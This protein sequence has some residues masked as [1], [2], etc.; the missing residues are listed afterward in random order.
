MII[1]NAMLLIGAIGCVFAPSINWLLISRFAQGIG[2]IV[3]V[4]VFAIIADSYQGNK[5]VKFIG[6]MN[7]ILTVVMAIAAILGSFINEAVGWRGSYSTVAV[8]CLI[9]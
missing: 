5:A 4:I 3:S 2:D 6:I 8:M 7:A 9:S 1:G